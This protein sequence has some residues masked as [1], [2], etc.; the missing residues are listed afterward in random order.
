MR[1]RGLR[2]AAVGTR[3]RRGEGERE[4]GRSRGTCTATVQ[5]IR[6]RAGFGFSASSKQP[7]RGS[8][9]QAHS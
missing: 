2:S 7:S 1:D 6:E 4:D 3:P 5:G 8:R 9:S